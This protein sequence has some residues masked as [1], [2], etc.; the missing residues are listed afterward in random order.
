MISFSTIRRVGASVA[1][2][3]GA[4]SVPH[5]AIYAQVAGGPPRDTTTGF[6]V[7]DQTTIAFCSGCHVRD[8]VGNLSRISFMRKT[9]EGWETSLRRMVSLNG[10]KVD[11]GAARKIVRYLSDN[12]GLAPAEARPGRFEAERRATDWSY[13]ASQPTDNTCH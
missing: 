10:V 8:S 13:S 9:P 6:P 12:Q 4:V 1:L 7:R 5:G 2:A 3:A 11:T